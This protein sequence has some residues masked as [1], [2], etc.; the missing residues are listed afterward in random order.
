MTPFTRSVID[1]IKDVPQGKVVTYG[2]VAHLAGSPRAARQVVRILHTQSAK[3]N[4]PW[5][6]VVMGDGSIGF[7]EEGKY[8]EQRILLE[9]EGVVFQGESI[10]LEEFLWKGN[11]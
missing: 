6:R 7:R 9:S 4:L 2:M 1:V 3:E 11:Q 10:S 8:M 5:H